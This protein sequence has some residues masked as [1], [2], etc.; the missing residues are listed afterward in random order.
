M[1]QKKFTITVE[2]VPPEG[3]DAKPILS[4]LEPLSK[5][6]IDNFSVA[7]NPVA[8]P[9][10]SAMALSSLIQ[11]KTGRPAILHCTTR[12]HNR[13]SLQGLLWGARA[14][15]IKTILAA[16]GDFVALGNRVATTTVR[17]LDIFGLVELGREAGLRTGVVIDPRPESNGLWQAIRWLERKVESGAQFAVT[18]PFFDAETV[19]R[20]AKATEHIEIPIIMG[21]LPLRTSRHAQFLHDRVSGI[22]VPEPVR[23]RMEE[24]KDPAAEGAANAREMIDLARTHFRGVCVM[25]PFEHYEMLAD[26]LPKKK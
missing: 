1:K 7:T 2:I 26:I 5:L 9:R 24:A 19:E 15:G 12:D 8:R 13:L 6:S 4:A 23:E 22:A 14:L 16:T 11:Q 10:M 21:V 3:P 25:P 18:Q 17:D 20:V